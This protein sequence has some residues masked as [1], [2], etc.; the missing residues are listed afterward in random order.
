[1]F[2]ISKPQN[3]GQASESSIDKSIVADDEPKANLETSGLRMA[4]SLTALI[5]LATPK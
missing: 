3:L 4:V 5:S 2:F 1:M